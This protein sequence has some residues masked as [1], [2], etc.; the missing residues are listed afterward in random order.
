MSK[1]AIVTGSGGGGCGHA[2]ARRFARDGMSVVV[3]DVDESGARDTIRFIHAER[4]RAVFLRADVGVEQEVS[5]LFAF[6]EKTFG[7]VDILVNNA[8]AP[9]HPEAPFAHWQETIQVDLLGAMYATL[10]ALRAFARRGGGAIVSMA[11]ISALGHGK[12]HAMV[13]A[14]DVAKAGL[15][16]MT[17]ALGMLAGQGVRVNCLAPGWIASRDVKAYV[18]SLAP[19]ERRERGVPD[20]L[21]SPDEIADAV[22]RLATDETLAGRVMVWWNGQPP[23]LIP[24]GDPGHAGRE[25]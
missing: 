19:A 13:P 8:S 14:Y 18:D 5:E 24:L 1:V 21:I 25:P 17:T 4:G 7:G 3:S 6:A 22:L 2:I 9:Y 15:I 10:C 16:R 12:D 20:V 23:F 11:S